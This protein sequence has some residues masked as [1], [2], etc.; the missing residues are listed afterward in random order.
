[1][2]MDEFNLEASLPADNAFIVGYKVDG[3][4]KTEIRVPVEEL[5]PIEG[6]QGPAGIPGLDGGVGPQG[7]V[8]PA[9]PPTYISDPHVIYVRSSGNDSTGQIGNPSLP[10]LTGTAAYNAGVAAAANFRLV[11]GTGSFIIDKKGI[12]LSTYFKAAIGCGFFPSNPGGSLTT[13]I[14]Y[15]NPET[16]NNGNGTAGVSQ[17]RVQFD[18][19]YLNW[20]NSG[21]SVST[22]DEVGNYTGGAGGALDVF[23][24]ALWALS[25]NGGDA[26]SN[27]N[28]EA[29]IGGAPASHLRV[30]GGYIYQVSNREGEGFSGGSPI[31]PVIAGQMELDGADLRY[32]NFGSEPKDILAGRCSFPSGL[33]PT[34]DKGGNSTW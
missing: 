6:P 27:A 7:P 32:S 4:T 20:V 26:S 31:A 14:I 3:L 29:G 30:T 33:T 1:M 25:T 28:G 34:T 19:L 17:P 16:V 18:N 24:N 12:E 15:T 21:G 23:G 5:A 22:V 13:L 2:K 11:F 8:G 9:G 10:F